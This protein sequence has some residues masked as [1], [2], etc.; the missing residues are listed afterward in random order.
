MSSSLIR[1][2]GRPQGL[3]ICWFLYIEA[4]DFPFKLFLKVKTIKV[5]RIKVKRIFP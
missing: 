2:N 1:N 3:C 5:K 4:Y